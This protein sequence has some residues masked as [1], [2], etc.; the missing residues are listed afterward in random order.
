[1]SGV[2]LT[3]ANDELSDA[4]RELEDWID[5]TQSWHNKCHGDVTGDYEG[6]AALTIQTDNAHKIALAA[7]VNALTYFAR[8]DSPHE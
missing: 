7:K 5:G 4:L 8:E 1:M 3:T 6:Q 2:I